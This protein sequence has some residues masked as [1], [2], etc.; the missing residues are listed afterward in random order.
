MA[1]DP[2]Q[3]EPSLGSAESFRSAADGRVRR[4]VPGLVVAQSRR[5]RLLPLDYDDIPQLSGL[6]A[7]TSA[8]PLLMDS[9]TRFIDVAAIVAC[10]HR[11]YA[12]ARG[13]G[14]W[15]AEALDGT[16][17]GLLSLLPVQGSDDLEIHVRLKP[18]AW[19]RWYAIEGT[20]LLCRQAFDVVGVPRLLGYCHPE[21]RRVRRIALRLGFRDLGLCEHRRQ[22]A[23]CYALDVATWRERSAA[24]AH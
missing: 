9:P 8:Y 12:G 19:G 23:Q 1:P 14:A 24:V 7:Q 10:V 22:L 6:F 16:F 21:H 2:F 5:M 3:S 13:L 4:A 18:E 17:V 20:H 15:R 11:L